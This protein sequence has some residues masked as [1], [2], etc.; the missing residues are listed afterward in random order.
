MLAPQTPSSL[1]SAGRAVT[2][3]RSITMQLSF[4]ISRLGPI[5][6]RALGV[7]LCLRLRMVSC[8]TRCLLENALI[9]IGDYIKVTCETSTLT[10]YYV[11]RKGDS[12]IHMATHTT[13]G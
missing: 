13:E 6:D 2:L 7:Q 10:H 1:L 8:G 9:N 11:V 5:S 3:L 12:T 4:N